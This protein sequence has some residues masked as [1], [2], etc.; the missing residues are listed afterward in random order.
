MSGPV[1]IIGIIVLAVAGFL[2][3]RYIQFGKSTKKIHQ[4][5]FDRIQPLLTKLDNGEK[6]SQ[7]EVYAY[8]ANMLTRTNTYL[9]MQKHGFTDIF[10]A[11][12]YTFEKAAESN[13]AR[14]LE[15]P[16][17]LDACPDKMEHVKRVTVDFDGKSNFVHYEVF[18]FRVNEPHW[19]AKN[20]WMIGI[21]G[22]YFD[23]S[24]PYDKLPSTFSR[25][26]SFE[27]TTPEDEAAWVHKN[28]SLK[29]R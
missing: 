4:Q 27:S 16:T 11:E 23:D 7:E 10:P 18:K 9:L 14:W 2:L 29:R 8:A 26:N 20:G 28:I 13:L 12:F 1:I 25:L 5:E 15:F 6:P 17:E 24:K 22:A 19:G 3:Y 21:A